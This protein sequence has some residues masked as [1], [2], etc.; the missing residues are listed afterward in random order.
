ME[1][2]DEDSTDSEEVA[3][4]AKKFR[5][6]IRFKNRNNKNSSLD[7]SKGDFQGA[8]QGKKD[9][10]SRSIQCYES[11]G[12]GH[13]WADCPNFKNSKGKAMNATLSNDSE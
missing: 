7:I 5:K 1:S 12:F 10:N 4:L 9:E 11:S 2:Y 8:T 3:M 13:V 6:F